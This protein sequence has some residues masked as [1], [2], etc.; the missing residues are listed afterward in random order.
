MCFGPSSL[1]ATSLLPGAHAG[2]ILASDIQQATSSTEHLS[3]SSL[4][5]LMDGDSTTQWWATAC[6]HMYSKTGRAPS[7]VGMVPLIEL[8]L[9]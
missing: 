7:S 8:P 2:T 6:T 9:S 1:L 4:S 5:A 3:A